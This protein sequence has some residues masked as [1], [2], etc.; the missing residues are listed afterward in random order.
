MH[1][2]AKVHP[3]T[4]HIPR[5]LAAALVFACFACFAALG[6]C[7]AA[8]AVVTGAAPIAAPMGLM[9]VACIGFGAALS[10]EIA[11]D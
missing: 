10:A 7:L 11:T 3:M 2:S 6:G 8:F 5:Y 1:N 4:K 9:S